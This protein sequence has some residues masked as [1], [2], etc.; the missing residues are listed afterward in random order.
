[1][2]SFNK[3]T[4][5]KSPVFFTPQTH[6]TSHSFPHLFQ[7]IFHSNLHNLPFTPPSEASDCQNFL[8][9]PPFFIKLYKR[10]SDK[11]GMGKK[12]TCSSV[13]SGEE[14]VKQT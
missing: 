13:G 9:Q 1:L 6:C 10:S 14:A 12:L 4:K 8:K 11:N 7:I 2:F 3:L 5:N